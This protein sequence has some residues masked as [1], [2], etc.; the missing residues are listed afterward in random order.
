MKTYILS[1]LGR[2]KKYSQKLDAEA[3]LYDKKWEVFNDVGD[4]EVL[5]FRPNKDLL[6][7]RNGRV[8]KGQWEILSPNTLL[9]EADSKAYLLNSAFV[10]ET[11]L[12]LQMDGTN[13]VMVL[14]EEEL[15]QKLQLENIEQVNKFLY[16]TEKEYKVKKNYS[17]YPDEKPISVK[18]KIKDVFIVIFILVLLAVLANLSWK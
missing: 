3:I 13:E 14:V 15:R 17:I 5:I 12:A 7:S 2:L 8:T 18:T 10:D 4:K 6:I 16:D 11:F 1:G 9:I